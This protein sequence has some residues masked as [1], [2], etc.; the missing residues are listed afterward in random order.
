MALL[1]L[2]SQMISY[3]YPSMKSVFL[4]AT[5]FGKEFLGWLIVFSSHFLLYVGSALAFLSTSHVS[6]EN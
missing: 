5:Y 1:F 2:F 6:G 4:M 3:W